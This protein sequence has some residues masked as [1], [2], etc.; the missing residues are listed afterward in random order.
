MLYNILLVVHVINALLLIIIVLLQTGKGADV[1]F[2]FG[3]GAANTMFGAG[4][5][6]NFITK[7][8]IFVAI[9]FMVT[10]LTL[11]LFQ[12]KR[13]GNYSGVLDSVKQS[14]SAV[15]AQAPI[16]EAPVVPV[17]NK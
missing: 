1:G 12:A 5:S 15:P 8:T 3:A 17:E 2:A 14:E 16:S 13:S 6:K 7:A 11:A 9:L 10:S 4:G